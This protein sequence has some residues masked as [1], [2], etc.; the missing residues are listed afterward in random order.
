[1][2][3]V[4]PLSLPEQLL[5]FVGV[6]G[7]ATALH[8][9]ILVALVN[10]AGLDATL[11]SSAGYALSTMFNY[12]L[13]RHLTF[14]SRRSHGSALPRFLLLAIVGLAINTATVWLLVQQF[15]LHYLVAQIVA[16]ALTLCWNFIA[17]RYWAF[18]PQSNLS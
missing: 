5:R 8:Y 9:L 2:S 1:M 3:A 16:T 15:A 11:A 10:S 12:A 7:L 13:N 18:A 4:K 6:G 17:A 14:R